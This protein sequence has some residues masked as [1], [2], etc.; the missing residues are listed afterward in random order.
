MSDIQY[1]IGRFQPQPAP[2]PADAR[3]GHV[4]R[5]AAL[6]GRARTAVAGLDDPQ[7]DTPYR[8]GGW[9]PRQITHH[10]ADSHLNAFVRI[11]LALTEDHPTIKPYD[12]ERWARQADVTAVPVAASLDILGG[13]HER[14][15]RLLRS[16]SEA[17]FA[18]T[19]KHPE[20]GDI[21]VDFLLQM[22]AWHGDHHVTQIE[23][24]RERR[25]W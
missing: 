15:V 17:D 22:Y 19:V 1:P 24:L 10:L 2:L 21:D 25:G 14:W 20:I 6:P 16:L 18:R 7:L 9:S 3:A 8:D 5:I 13:L 12:Q 4:D 11:K 23:R